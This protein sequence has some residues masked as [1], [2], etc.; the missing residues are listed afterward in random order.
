MV[1]N[2]PPDATMLLRTQCPHCPG[3]LNH[4]SELVK[5]GELGSLSII[6]VEHHPDD[7]KAYGVRSVPWV[8]ID[9]YEL[10]GAQDIGA[11][12]Q[13]IKW[14][15]N[16]TSLAGEFDSWLSGAQVE[17][18]INAIHEK[19]ESISVIVELLR[20]PATV[21]STRI[22]I[23]VVMEEF[24]GSNMLKQLI[25]VLGELSD[26]NDR[27]VRTDSLHYLGL[28][29][30]EEAIPVLERYLANSTKND[31]AQEV[32]EESLETLIKLKE[33]RHE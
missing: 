25:P 31:E 33:R 30:S 13:R 11:L 15:M 8:K 7:A 1:K 32:A 27:R 5:A 9:D 19:P 18:V 2:T 3:V 10:T 6:N 22:G 21:L 17:K 26:H 20:D 23:G 12:R 4:L 29:E 16:A 24:A 28:T 14:A